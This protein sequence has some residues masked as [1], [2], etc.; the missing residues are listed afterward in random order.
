MGVPFVFCFCRFNREK[1]RKQIVT[2]PQKGKN[3][4]T[5]VI[6]KFINVLK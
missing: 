1:A 6:H 4:T 2:S 3:W 5:V